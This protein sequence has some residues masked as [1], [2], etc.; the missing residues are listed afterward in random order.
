VFTGPLKV[1]N[2]YEIVDLA[3]QLGQQLA[4]RDHI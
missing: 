2:P 3:L 4:L 1:G